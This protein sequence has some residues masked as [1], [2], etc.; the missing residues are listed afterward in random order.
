MSVI[1]I[2]GNGQVKP[3]LLKKKQQVS[4]E[5]NQLTPRQ[6]HNTVGELTSNNGCLTPAKE[7]VVLSSLDLLAK[8]GSAENIEFLFNTLEH[9]NYGLKKGGLLEETL[10]TTSVIAPNSPK[11]N[12]NWEEALLSTLEKAIHS[13]TNDIQRSSFMNRLEKAKT[14]SEVKS[15]VSSAHYISV[16]PKVPGS[17]DQQ[18][19]KERET[20]LS[21]AE[22]M[23]SP[24]ES[25]EAAVKPQ[26]EELL[27]KAGMPSE[28]TAI[29]KNTLNKLIEIPDN[30]KTPLFEAKKEVEQFIHAS[31][32]AF[33]DKVKLK[34]ALEDVN[35]EEFSHDPKQIEETQ[36]D[37]NNALTTI[38][39]IVS[40]S[41]EPPAL[42]NKCLETLHR[43]QTLYNGLDEMRLFAEK[44]CLPQEAKNTL[45]TL[46]QSLIFSKDHANKQSIERNLDYFIA[47]SEVSKEEKSH[48]L[49]QL[50]HL[51]SSDYEI[52]SQLKDKKIQVV[53]EI[54]NDITTS[55]P[56]DELLLT[57]RINQR[58]HGS[59]AAT[60]H[61][62]KL[63]AHSFKQEYVDVLLQELNSSGTMKVYSPYSDDPEEKITIEKPEIEYEHLLKKNYRVLDASLLRWMEVGEMGP[64]G[65]KV[66]RFEDND[67]EHYGMLADAH[68]LPDLEGESKSKQYAL[69]SCIKLE[70]L[71]HELKS[72]LREQKEAYGTMKAL[73]PQYLKETQT[74]TSTVESL[75]TSYFNEIDDKKS[76]LVD[77]KDIR[78]AAKELSDNLE[79]IINPRATHKGESVF[80]VIENLEDAKLDVAM[81]LEDIAPT[82]SSMPKEKS[83]KV[84]TDIIKTAAGKS[85][86]VQDY[87][88]AQKLHTPKARFSHFHNL[89]KVAAYS[90][91]KVENELDTKEG[92][93]AYAQKYHTTADKNSILTKMEDSG[94]LLREKDLREM[95]SFFEERETIRRN[96]FQEGDFGRFSDNKLYKLPRQYEQALKPLE[97]SIDKL[98]REIK[99]DHVNYNI[100]LTPEL[101]KLA[102]EKGIENGDYW[103]FEE[104]DSGLFDKESKLIPE[105]IVNKPFTPVTD[106]MQI[107]DYISSAQAVGT[108]SSSVSTLEAAGHSQYIYD[109]RDQG[110]LNPDTGEMES[111]KAIVHDNSWGTRSEKEHTWRDQSG[112]TRTDYKNDFGGSKGYV[113]YTNGTQASLI[114]DVLNASF[115]KGDSNYPMYMGGN[116]SIASDDAKSKASYLLKKMMILSTDEP[117]ILTNAYVDKL[118]HGNQSDIYDFLNDVNGGLYEITS[119]TIETGDIQ[120]LKETMKGLIEN[121]KADSKQSIFSDNSGSMANKAASLIDKELSKLMPKDMELTAKKMSAADAVESVVNTLAETFVDAETNAPAKMAFVRDANEAL[122]TVVSEAI[123]NNSMNGL[124][125]AVKTKIN[126]IIETA[127]PS[128]LTPQAYSSFEDCVSSKYS[129]KLE[130]I[131]LTPNKSVVQK[132]IDATRA[133]QESI[134]ASYPAFVTF[135]QKPTFNLIEGIAHTSSQASKR[136]LKQICG[137][138]SVLAPGYRPGVDIYPEGIK[139]KADFEK[140]PENG[141]LHTMLKKMSLQEFFGENRTSPI[142]EEAQT[143]DEL[144]KAQAEI[145]KYQKELLKPWFNKDPMSTVNRYLEEL[146]SSLLTIQNEFGIDLS[147]LNPVIKEVCGSMEVAKDFDGSLESSIKPFKLINDKL[148]ESFKSAMGPDDDDIYEA[149]Q[150]ELP[151]T[152][153]RFKTKLNEIPS[154]ET[155]EKS[156]D[157]AAKL[158]V[159]VIDAKFQPKTNEEFMSHVK[160]LQN[161]TFDDFQ[162]FI[163]DLT[164]EDLGITFKDPYDY[165]VDIRAGNQDVIQKLKSTVFAHNYSQKFGHGDDIDDLMETAADWLQTEEA[166]NLSPEAQEAKINEDIATYYD[167]E[168]DI[169]ELFLQLRGRMFGLNVGDLVKQIEKP[170]AEMGIRPAFPDV[171]ALN[172]IQVSNTVENSLN[173]FSDVLMD[174]YEL[175]QKVLAVSNNSFVKSKLEKELAKN[176]KALSEEAGYLVKAL[177]RPCH[178]DNVRQKLNLYMKT[179]LKNPESVHADALRTSLAEDMKKDFILNYPVEFVEE[180]AKDLPTMLS[181]NKTEPSPTESK[182]IDTW[183]SFLSLALKESLFSTIEDELL[184][185]SDAGL[186]TQQAKAF[187]NIYQEKLKNVETGERYPLEA[188]E[189]MRTIFMLLSDPTNNNEVFKLFIQKMGLTDAAYNFAAGEPSPEIAITEMKEQIGLL[190]TFSEDS[191][192]LNNA[193]YDFTDQIMEDSNPINTIAEAVDAFVDSLQELPIQ[194]PDNLAN[195]ATAFREAL[196]TV[197]STAT[198]AEALSQTGM[199]PKE[200]INASLIGIQQAIEEQQPIAI[201]TYLENIGLIKEDL[202]ARKTIISQIKDLPNPADKIN[203]KIERFD[204][205]LDRAISSSE[206]LFNKLPSDFKDKIDVQEELAVEQKKHKIHDIKDFSYEQIVTLSQNEAKETIEALKTAIDNED[207]KERAHLAAKL[208]KSPSPIVVGLLQKELY[209]PNSNEMNAFVAA[210]LANKGHVEMLADYVDHAIDEEG[211]IKDDC[212]W[213][214]ALTTSVKNLIRYMN[215]D[216]PAI[217]DRMSDSLSKIYDAACVDQPT[218]YEN[219]LMTLFTTLLSNSGE[220]AEKFVLDKFL[221]PNS[222]I[223]GRLTAAIA[224]A[225]NDTAKFMPLFEDILDDPE[226]YIP[227][228]PSKYG[229]TLLLLGTTAAAVNNLCVMYDW[230]KKSSIMTKLENLDVDALFEKV[231]DE[232]FLNEETATKQVMT[233]VNYIE[234]AKETAAEKSIFDEEGGLMELME[235]QENGTGDA[236]EEQDL[237]HLKR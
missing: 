158:I 231:V 214:T 79:L 226:K 96:G 213:D 116:L 106:P 34:S 154:V 145:I 95:Q 194:D 38:I 22:F 44:S 206:K 86:V 152:F 80:D 24:W 42:K 16:N 33:L 160:D 20:L 101:K 25:F 74:C 197:E 123:E 143:I 108:T 125:D 2:H 207:G 130:M 216:D 62:R 234:S 28:K 6:A 148:I 141:L 81:A 217:S 224:L 135:A 119:Y 53:A 107:I 45:V 232:G 102:Y 159:S 68:L 115:P 187:R 179:F 51:L 168:V 48:C 72:N 164:Q 177:V 41:E 192:L 176:E 172:K 78:L 188:P 52:D 47:S 35:V 26:V 204:K 40:T 218:D 193:F 195:Y 54:L 118:L 219:E 63:P 175:K 169:N 57:K 235:L 21:S 174:V 70:P 220:K 221:N 9:L 209:E 10:K 227:D 105:F 134:E 3:N 15:P 196:S 11:Q 83:D 82:L 138:H 230:P 92:R 8:D 161:M 5:G 71:L 129:K 75:L 103:V 87:E 181:S 203:K 212:Q 113:S 39:E 14:P 65:K 46:S 236:S 233:L 122:F 109:V 149:L 12:I 153:E 237:K 139:S 55:T 150:E 121:I 162:Y 110:V 199:G 29:Y 56:D 186:M 88:A 201:N 90:R 163:N 166:A 91:V 137:D 184:E 98:Y 84:I 190:K 156:G 136:L 7:R 23:Q 76:N 142:V 171:R 100:E 157:R 208:A 93:E 200:L 128:I 165:V 189:S 111:K 151:K 104:G 69:R 140:L 61:G 37:R 170:A 94:K 155:L 167:K 126:E 215:V 131:A 73:E 211:L 185:S 117:E 27:A 178:Q 50:N 17:I 112:L 147:G 89:F 1:S 97:A 32:L 67:H 222:S 124:S 182:L 144:N 180:M 183:S 13:N 58:G 85:Q 60:S 43:S 173:Q 132:K 198:I 120:G 225:S 210:T 133:M 127:D 64:G 223:N 30:Q 205:R 229:E 36:N 228:G 59:C 49:S 19:L 202:K 4:F 77:K 99:R 18:I 114:E 66:G 146:D 31:S 191:E